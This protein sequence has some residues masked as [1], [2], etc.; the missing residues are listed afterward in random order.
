MKQELCTQHS[1]FGEGFAVKPPIF[2][3]RKR[4]IGVITSS[5]KRSRSIY[6]LS[7]KKIWVG[8]KNNENCI[9]GLTRITVKDKIKSRGMVVL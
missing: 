1:I 2:D 9:E 7:P 8:Q 5:T 3:H 4:K 6:Q